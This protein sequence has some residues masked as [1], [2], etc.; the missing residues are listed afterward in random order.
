MYPLGSVLRFHTALHSMI[1]SHLLVDGTYC[2][3]FYNGCRHFLYR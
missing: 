2:V 3:M 1:Y